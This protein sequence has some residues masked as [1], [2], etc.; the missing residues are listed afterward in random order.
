MDR[1]RKKGEV[2]LAEN[3]V[4]PSKELPLLFLSTTLN[5][6]YY[7]PCFTDKQAGVERG[8]ITCA[9]L[10]SQI[11]TRPSAWVFCLQVQQPFH[12]ITKCI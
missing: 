1:W 4:G 10:L 7:H 9:G 8:E 11:G 12:C 2:A 5:G 6:V 3:L